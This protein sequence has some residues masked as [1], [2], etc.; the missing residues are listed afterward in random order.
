MAGFRVQTIAAGE[1]EVGTRA[2]GRRLHHV[3]IRT[4]RQAIRGERAGTASAEGGP[5]STSEDERQSVLHRS[6]GIGDGDVARLRN[7]ESG[8]PAM[9]VL[10]RADQCACGC[11]QSHGHGE[12]GVHR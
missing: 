7:I 12:F 2:N 10:A 9:K 8:D 11:R 1:A 4:G 3:L 6:H 5:I